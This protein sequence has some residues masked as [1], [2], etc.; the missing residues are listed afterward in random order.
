MRALRIVTLNIWNNGGPW[1]ERLLG[2]R[3]GLAELEPD[4]VGLQEVLRPTS[5]E[6]PDQ[7]KERLSA[8]TI[9]SPPN[10]AS[11]TGASTTFSCGDRMRAGAASPSM[12]TFASIARETASILATTSA[13]ALQYASRVERCLGQTPPAFSDVSF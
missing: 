3:A 11:P 5:S 1:T 8:G 10:F 9:H 6:G 2:I 4:V 12:H 7:A 13:S